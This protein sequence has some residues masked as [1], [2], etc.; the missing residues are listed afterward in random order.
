M[1]YHENKP[2]PRK[3]ADP[4]HWADPKPVLSPE[5]KAAAAKIHD[6]AWEW[7]GSSRVPYI[8]QAAIEKYVKRCGGA[9]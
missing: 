4:E 3:D 7:E 2:S 8:I 5:A 9:E 6:M 1:S